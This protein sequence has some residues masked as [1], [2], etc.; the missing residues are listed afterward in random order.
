MPSKDRMKRNKRKDINNCY[1]INKDVILSER[2]EKYDN[3]L[4]A[5]L[6]STK[7]SIIKIMKF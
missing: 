7:T 6:K 4:L 5:P 3:H 1:E 2:K